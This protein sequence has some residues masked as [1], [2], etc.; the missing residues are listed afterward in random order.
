MTQKS[1]KVVVAY[2][3]RANWEKV[4]VEKSLRKDSV[5]QQGQVLP[6]KDQMKRQMSGNIIDGLIEGQYHGGDHDSIDLEK[7]GIADIL[8]K[9][10]MY[11]MAKELA[12]AK[13]GSAVK[14]HKELKHQQKIKDAEKKKAE[15]EQAQKLVKEAKEK[16]K[17]E[18][19]EQK[20]E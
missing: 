18:Q 14:V 13:A 5:V 1:K 3:N 9:Q 2:R 20:S 10:N 15:L 12:I 19:P 4:I 11:E 7:Y 8:E 16:A 6:I 17:V